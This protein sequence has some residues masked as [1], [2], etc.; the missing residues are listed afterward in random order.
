MNSDALTLALSRLIAIAERRNQQES[1]V[2]TARRIRAT[3][4]DKTTY[5]ALGDFITCSPAERQ[6]ILNVTEGLFLQ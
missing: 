1:I 6:K 4:K 5:S 3:T 2:A